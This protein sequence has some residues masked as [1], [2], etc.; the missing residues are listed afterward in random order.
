MTLSIDP[1][2]TWFGYNFV[3]KVQRP[4]PNL[5]CIQAMVNAVLPAQ[6]GQASWP[7]VC[8]YTGSLSLNCPAIGALNQQAF[9]SSWLA[10]FLTSWLAHQ[11]TLVMLDMFG[12]SKSA[13][14][15]LGMTPT[16]MDVRLLGERICPFLA[17]SHVTSLEYM[18]QGSIFIRDLFPSEKAQL[19]FEMHKVGR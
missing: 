16:Y 18:F 17:P 14:H 12:I 15:S 19:K 9:L 2:L 4:D 3:S 5:S 10:H 1:C 11:L 13:W 8:E 7:V 6:L